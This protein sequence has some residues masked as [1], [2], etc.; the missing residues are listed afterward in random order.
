MCP[1][2][3]GNQLRINFF[4]RLLGSAKV[5]NLCGT[6]L[7]KNQIDVVSRLFHLA[8]PMIPLLPTI[9]R[10][11]EGM[12]HHKPLESDFPLMSDYRHHGHV[13]PEQFDSYRMSHM[14]RGH[15]HEVTGYL[16]PFALSDHH[17]LWGHQQRYHPY[18]HEYVGRRHHTPHPHH[19]DHPYHGR[20]HDY[21]NHQ[22]Y[23]HDHR[24]RRRHGE[25]LDHYR[26]PSHEQRKRIQSHFSGERGQGGLH[27]SPDRRTDHSQD[28]PL[29]PKLASDVGHFIANVAHQVAS[30]LGTVG[31]CAKGPR[32]TFEAL[33]WNLPPMVA[34]EQGRTVES[35]GLFDRVNPADVRPGDY[36]Y[37][38][39]N[40]HVTA[41]HGID[42]GDSFIV[43]AVGRNGQIY[44]S[45]DHHFAV[46]PD[47]GRYRDLKFFRPNAK[48]FELYGD[49]IPHLQ[50]T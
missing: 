4:C 40:A 15:H 20:H 38:H 10:A 34:T 14:P 30:K 37:R 35:S 29:I 7:G 26:H 46:P 50:K 27:R 8:L 11:P 17:R 49:K 47:G 48:F 33:G 22:P 2:R 6:A 25:N 13:R 5:Q 18:G 44:G 45:N 3:A 24:H 23:D 43:H 36:G 19:P 39:W 42:K 31:D 21:Q 32:K 1:F 9:C 28:Q 12:K 41:K 16:P